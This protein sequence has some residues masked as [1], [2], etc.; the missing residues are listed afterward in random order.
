MIKSIKEIEI[1]NTHFNKTDFK[2]II[3]ESIS[4]NKTINK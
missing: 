3:I 4:E 2:E 1:I